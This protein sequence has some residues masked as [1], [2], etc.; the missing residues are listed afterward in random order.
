M[1]RSRSYGYSL[2]HRDDLLNALLAIQSASRT[3][4][5]KDSDDRDRQIYQAGFDAALL[6]VA[7]MIGQS[8]V[9]LAQKS[10]LRNAAF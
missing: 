10:K 1:D 6:A 9:F 8:E 5:L 4:D 7:Q 2:I 3:L